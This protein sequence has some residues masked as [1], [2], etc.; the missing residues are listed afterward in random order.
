MISAYDIHQIP[1]SK[2]DE[3]FGADA[4]LYTRVKDYGS[5][6]I[7]INSCTVVDVEGRLVDVK[8]GITLWKGE[9]TCQVNSSDGGGGIIGMMISA[10]ITQVISSSSDQAHDICPQAN[11]QLLTTR[12]R[13]LLYGPRHPEYQT[14]YF[15]E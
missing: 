14:D 15:P 1:L 13:G 2:I 7:V 11:A 6:Y 8:S 10:A 9:A 12:D 5:E 4:V 3:I